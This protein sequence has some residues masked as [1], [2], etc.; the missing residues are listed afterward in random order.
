MSCGG[1]FRSR[2]RKCLDEDLEG[3]YDDFCV[4]INETAEACHEFNCMPS[5]LTILPSLA[6]MVMP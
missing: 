6:F 3:N 4:G 5:E 2:Y 1:G